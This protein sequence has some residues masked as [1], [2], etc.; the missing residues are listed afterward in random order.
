MAYRSSSQ[1]H[2]PPSPTQIDL[3]L[4]VG[5]RLD[6]KGWVAANDGN[7][8]VRE[9]DGTFLVTASGAPKGYLRRDQIL[10]VDSEGKVLSGEGRPSSEL[11]LHLTIYRERPDVSAVVH[12]HPPVSTAYAVAREPLDACVLP[13]LVLTLGRIPIAPYATPG[14]PELGAS[15]VD[16][17]RTHDA[18]L[19]ANHGAVTAG[20]DL[21]SAYFT[22]ERVEHGARILLYAHLLGRVTPLGTSE[23][24]R[25]LA[26]SGPRAGGP[27]P[28]VPAD[29][30]VGSDAHRHRE[31][32]DEVSV[33]GTP[34][35][36]ASLEGADAMDL[37]RVI[38]EVLAERLE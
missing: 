36:P 26:T 19:L 3:F 22:M 30:A 29:T 5:R 9:S 16:A 1:R 35:V 10:R 37:A 34:R 2:A 24:E 18:V 33:P 14:T 27:I 21:E 11:G 12:A 38:R 25:L 31:T 6:A 8:S 13:E 23:V 4:E 17:I 32:G 28:C 20:K 15:I 7:L